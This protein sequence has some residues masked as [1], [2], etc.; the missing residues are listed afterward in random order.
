[1]DGTVL[2]TGANG[3]LGLPFIEH[4]ISSYPT[5]TIIA[6]V[7]NPSPSS[8]PNTA[9]LARTIASHDTSRA[10]IEPLDLSSLANVR[11]FA[12][13]IAARVANKQLPPLAAIVCNAFTWSLDGQHATPDGFESTFQVGHL[14]H[15]LLVLKLLGAM[16]R[17][18]RVVMLGSANHY[19]EKPV[20][21]SK[22]GA[23]FPDG[24]DMLVKPGA[25]EPG[26]EHDRGFQRYA[27]TKLANVMFMQDLG[28]RL[29]KD[30][31][32]SGITVTAM[33][34][35]GLVD[36]RAHTAQK[37]AIR[38]LMSIANAALPLLRPFTSE[39]RRSADSAK[40]L[41]ELSVGDGFRDARGYYVG[42]KKTEPARVVGDEDK[43]RALWKAC[44][45][46]ASLTRDETVLVHV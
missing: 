6:A 27:T 8:D 32:L 13:S 5:Y 26:N 10:I 12:N 34:P 17:T 45:G 38:I 23:A 18:G 2:I 7:R 41:V 33:D 20:P 15:F 44:W 37:P 19:P 21:I 24:V 25:D 22:L 36:S 16:S 14:A 1:M 46:W 4:I 40:D 39:V 28:A 43:V 42:L 31:A 3:S 30:P 29:K 9:A 35:G 11:S